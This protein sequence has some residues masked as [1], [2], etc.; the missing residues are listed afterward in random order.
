MGDRY[1]VCPVNIEHVVMRSDKYDA[2]ACLQRDTW[3]ESVCSNPTCEFCRERPD[4]PREL[5]QEA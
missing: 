3:L 2:Y 1:P 4:Q 5:S